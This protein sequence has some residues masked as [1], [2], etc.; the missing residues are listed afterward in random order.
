M[1]KFI[2]KIVNLDKIVYFW[3]TNLKTYDKRGSFNLELYYK[4][5]DAKIQRNL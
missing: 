4:I 5:K 3:E 1:K 2:D